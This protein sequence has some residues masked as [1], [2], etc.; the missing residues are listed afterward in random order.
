MQMWLPNCFCLRWLLN[1][2]AA[3]FCTPV[4]CEEDEDFVCE[5]VWFFYIVTGYGTY[6][7]FITQNIMNTEKVWVQ[8]IC[9]LL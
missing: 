7:K 8:K 9:I 1:T 5:I 4:C 3:L 2:Q 6:L